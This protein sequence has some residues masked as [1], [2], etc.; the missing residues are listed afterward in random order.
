[1]RADTQKQQFTGVQQ[2]L[3]NALRSSILQGDFPPGSRLRQVEVADRFGV[4]PVPLREALSALEREGL[5]VRQP[6]RGWYVVQLEEDEI[7]EIY[8]LRILL[9][10]KAIQDAVPRLT[11]E[12]IAQLESLTASLAQANNAFQHFELRERFYTTLYGATRKPRLVAMIM[13]LHNQLAMHLRLQRI[14]HSTHSHNE[15][16]DAIRDRDVALASDL[17]RQ[18]LNEIAVRA[19]DAAHVIRSGVANERS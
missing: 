11:D 10:Q 14:E 8:E 18:H 5:V 9:E 15:L 1:M 16:M 13:S 19:I 17:V 6:R 2:Q 12:D 7:R 4:S 3:T